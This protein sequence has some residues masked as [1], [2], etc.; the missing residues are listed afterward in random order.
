MC[1]NGEKVKS[2]GNY[3]AWTIW[4]DIIEGWYLSDD[5]LLNVFNVDQKQKI[6]L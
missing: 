6:N 1:L 5:R 4:G 3:G 2:L